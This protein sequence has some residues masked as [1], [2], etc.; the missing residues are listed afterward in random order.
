MNIHHLELFY[1]VA[2]HGGISTAVRHMPYGIQQPA[3]SSQIR[4]LET[5]LRVRLF[6]RK[7][8]KLTP[9]GDK[10]LAFARPFFDHVDAVGAALGK[11]EPE[12]VRI[13]GSEALLRDHMPAVMQRVKKH[14]P[15]LRL[16]MHAGF[17]PQLETELRNRELDLAFVTAL[18]PRVGPGLRRSVLLR[19]PL[20]L[21]VHRKSRIKS[22][23]EL[24]SRE[25][26]DE[27]LVSSVPAPDNIFQKGLKRM[28][29][30]WR[31][32]IEATS[33]QLV[34]WYVAHGHGIGV[35]LNL[36]ELVRHPQVRVLPLEGFDPVEIVAI[37]RGEPTPMIRAIVNESRRYAHEKFPEIAGD[38]PVE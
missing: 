30:E 14:H 20:V 32:S 19:M 24:W 34:T 35:N 2:R 8:F 36:P 6:D 12:Q 22:A 18:Q 13:G 9:E 29:V 5:A 25:R 10:L 15:G 37:W 16:A 33:L 23:A 17:Q 7:P 31:P 4:Q 3:V 28:G 11:P 26:I 1:Y 27:P 21:I 38:K